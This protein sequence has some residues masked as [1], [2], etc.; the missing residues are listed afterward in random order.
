MATPIRTQFLGKL[1]SDPTPTEAGQWWYNT[2]EKRWK[3][4]DGEETRILPSR[5]KKASVTVT[6]PIGGG[7]VNTSLT[8]TDFGLNNAIEYIIN[9]NVIRRDPIINTVYAPSAGI[10]LNSQ[11]VGL[12]L[13]AGAGTTLTA[14]V[15]VLGY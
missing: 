12:T 4:Y 1:S 7:R 15:T 3:Y 10:T 6:I 14:E 9:V 11:A 8:L 2:T 5:L 13:A